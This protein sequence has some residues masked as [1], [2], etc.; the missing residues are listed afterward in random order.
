MNA[1]ISAFA[2]FTGFGDEAVISK[3]D[4]IRKDCRFG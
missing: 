4:Q 2:F 3:C 1:N